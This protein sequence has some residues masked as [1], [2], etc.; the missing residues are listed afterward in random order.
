MWGVS[1]LSIFI[2]SS[3]DCRSR[4]G[5][6][7]DSMGLGENQAMFKRLPFVLL[8]LVTFIV[9]GDSQ[10]MFSNPITARGAD[11][12]VAF[13]TGNYYSVQSGCPHA[14]STPVIC[15][16]KAAS[17]AEL[18]LTKPVPVWAAPESGPNSHDIWAPEIEYLNG[19][20]YIYYA[21]DPDVNP[22]HSLFA[23]VPHD[24]SNPLGAWQEADTGVP[25][26]GFPLDWKSNWAIDPSVFIASDGRLYLLFACRQDNSNA[27]P[28]NS[29]SIC[30][31]A[32]RDPLHLQPNPITGKRVVA[33]SYPTRSW[34]NRFFPTQEGPF[35]F[36]RDGVDYI[37]YSASF[38]GTPDDYAEGLL[39][40]RHP[41]QP[42]NQGNP[43]LNPASW[44]KEGPVFDGHHASYG[45]ASGVLVTSPDMTELWHVYHGTDCLENCV[46]KNN[47]TWV[48]RSIRAQKGGW[49]PS[50]DLV[51]GY[52]TDI[53]NTDGTGKGV[54]QR[55][56]STDGHGS[57]ILPQ[58]G[59]A[60]GDAAEGET[61]AGT[62]IGSWTQSQP[63]VLANL[64]ADPDRLDRTFFASN[65]NLQNYVLYTKIELIEKARKGAS[66]FGAYAAYVDRKNNYLV[67]IDTSCGDRACLFTDG[68]VHGNPIGRQNCA[69]PADFDPEKTNTL[70]IE[71][72]NGEF[73]IAVNEQT[74]SG[75]CQGRKFNL[76]EGQVA[77][78]GSNGQVGVAVQNARV[79]YTSFT[80]SP[81]VP[82]DSDQ[83]S[84]VFAFRN[85]QNAL[86]LDVA[87]GDCKNKNNNET[88]PVVESPAYA[89]YPLPAWPGQF[90]RLRTQGNRFSIVNA[91][92]GMCLEVAAAKGT[93][94]LAPVQARCNGETKQQW[95]FLPAPK[96]SSF[97]I[98]NEA[99]KTALDGNDIKSRRLSLSVRA[100]APSAIWQLVTP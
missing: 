88:A 40:N 86:E 67:L 47:K 58:W 75:P 59:A 55:G 25:S 61:G 41:P 92:T 66:Q 2:L 60:F 96:K 63:G 98:R 48:D 28:G 4:Q 7:R 21:A 54:P 94:T 90:W 62:A 38:S 22:H 56:P 65:P 50:G 93:N 32:M 29:Q 23:L 78:N 26:G 71:V 20:W 77:Q 1:G 12:S 16:R 91:M 95:D 82:V 36:T 79:Q 57:M 72:V 97:I 43:L 11:P 73:Q 80:V 89:P 100:D 45:T 9:A 10:G 24:P 64:S 37:L 69:L 81:E 19:R 14:G 51:L 15:I 68:T 85:S 70:A 31:S 42:N 34:E 39:V 13:V 44:V 33:L 84:T 74:L 27:K 87:C 76:N 46:L 52:P 30:V 83:N 53:Q 49:S 17:L 6:R 8:M 5:H 18:G 35:G 3:E 99:T